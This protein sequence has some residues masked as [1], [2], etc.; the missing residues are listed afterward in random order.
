MA[1]F[2]TVKQGE[3]KNLTLTVTDS[4]VAVDLMGAT[5]FFGV[6]RQKS[7][8]AY[9]FSK[10]DEDFDKGQVAQG[11]IRVFLTAANTAQ[12]PGPYVGELKVSWPGNPA[13]V[14]KSSNLA[15]IVEEA[16]TA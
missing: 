7:D 9:I 10:D 14:D 3:A 4:G 1:K 12:T 2:I 6:K 8:A 11:I 13:R 15:L 16:V 5:L